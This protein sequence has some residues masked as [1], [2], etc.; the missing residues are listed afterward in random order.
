MPA[1]SERQHDQ[2]PRDSDAF[3]AHSLRESPPVDLPAPLAEFLRSCAVASLL[4]PTDEH[5]T[6]IVSKLPRRLIEAVARPLPAYLRYLL[7]SCD[8]APVI[9]TLVYFDDHPMDPLG[10]E[11]F[12]NVADPDQR[13]EFA[14]LTRQPHLPVFFFDEHLVHRLSVVLPNDQRAEAAF[15]LNTGVRLLAALRAEDIDFDRA[16]LTVLRRTGL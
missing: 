8:T 5:G 9:R 12:T 4:H 3:L 13:K 11:C 14:A 2:G 6:V 7:Y 1:S 10:L 15:V 16:K